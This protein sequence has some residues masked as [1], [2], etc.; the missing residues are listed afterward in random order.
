MENPSTHE[1][2]KHQVYKKW[3]MVEEKE[4]QQ[5]GDCL[6]HFPTLSP[7]LGGDA[8]FFST[9]PGHGGN[10]N[11]RRNMF[12]TPEAMGGRQYLG[13]YYDSPFCGQGV[14]RMPQTACSHHVTQCCLA[15]EGCAQCD[16]ETRTKKEKRRKESGAPPSPSAIVSTPTAME[17]KGKEACTFSGPASF[18]VLHPSR[19]LHVDDAPSPTG[20][21]GIEEKDLPH[22]W[23]EFV[24]NRLSVLHRQLKNVESL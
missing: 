16:L 9:F 24:R 6:G 12:D 19:V 3:D 2:E 4:I 21:S 11:H 17:G 20:G 5:K 18:L 8:S 7:F 1:D 15:V 10:D 23:K 14:L 13:P 22:P